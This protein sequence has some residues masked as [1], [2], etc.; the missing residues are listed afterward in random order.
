MYTVTFVD[1]AHINDIDGLEITFPMPDCVGV[2]VENPAKITLA[3]YH[4]AWAIT[5]PEHIEACTDLDRAI[6]ELVADERRAT[7]DSGE[8]IAYWPDTVA[9]TDH[10]RLR[11]AEGGGNRSGTRLP[12]P[13]VHPQLSL[14]CSTLSVTTTMGPPKDNGWLEP[15]AGE[16]IYGLLMPSASSSGGCVR[17]LTAGAE[18]RCITENPRVTS[19]LSL[20]T[21]PYSSV[22]EWNE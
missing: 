20:S 3:T 12:T 7:N 22:H 19:W 14:T 16:E 9:L 13:A 8:P 15:R 11:A 5:R 1:V 4:V 6:A 17:L 21:S 10:R 2:L 18:I